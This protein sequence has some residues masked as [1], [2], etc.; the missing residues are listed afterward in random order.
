MAGLFAGWTSDLHVCWTHSIDAV[1]FF[2][3]FVEFDIPK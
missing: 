3:L 2:E 1:E